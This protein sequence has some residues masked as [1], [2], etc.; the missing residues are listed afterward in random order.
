MKKALALILALAMVFC[1]MAGCG[2]DKEDTGSSKKGA[3][4]T[5][6]VTME[7]GK[8]LAVSCKDEDGE[9]YVCDEDWIV[10]EEDG[11]GVI[12]FNG[13]EYGMEWTLSGDDFSFEDVDGD[14]F[15][16]TY[17]DGTIEGWYG[18]VYEYVFELEGGAAPAKKGE[19]ES[20]AESG[21]TPVSGSL[22]GCDVTI[23]GA[24]LFTDGDD[25][26]AIRVYWD[27][28]NNNDETIT[29]SWDIETLVEQEGFE[30]DTTYTWDDVPEYGNDSRDI[31][32]G[33]TIRCISEYNCKADGDVITVT[34]YDYYNEDD[35]V[36]AEFDPANLPGR[37]AEDWVAT[38]ITEPT[39]VEGLPAEGPVGEGYVV[40][41]HAE[42]VPSYDEGEEVVR[43]YFQYTNEGE[44]ETTMWSEVYYIA[45]QDGIELEIEWPAEDVAEDENMT[46]YVQ[47]GETLLCSECFALSSDSPI[48]IEVYDIWEEDYLGI[49]YNPA[50]LRG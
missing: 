42:I 2:S 31:Q 13:E 39:W 22:A 48:E 40:I 30:M 33:V 47:P 45:Y 49:I 44:E 20:A 8:Y 29:P 25:K 32:P 4:E 35:K 9:E 21:F 15:E 12:V 16:G 46:D 37:P 36:V 23:V 6:T 19:T 7:P 38:P 43:V 34:L 11:A 24:E 17:A 10:I 41:D 1:L 3:A 26:D 14:T 5:A 50:D 27:V 18:G 28:T